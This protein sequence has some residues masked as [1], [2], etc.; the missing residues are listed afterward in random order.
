MDCQK[1]INIF[2]SAIIDL[3]DNSAIAQNTK[4]EMHKNI[5]GNEEN[6]PRLLGVSSTTKNNITKVKKGIFTSCKKNDKCPP[7][8]I[9]AEEVVHD[10]EKKKLTYKNALLKV[11]NLPVFYLPKF[12][13]PDPTVERQS[14]FLQPSINDSDLLGSS[15]N[16]PYFHV[17]SDNKDLTINPVLFDSGDTGKIRMLQG[18]Y[19]Q[20]N[21]NSSFIADFGLTE[22]FKSQS[23]NDDKNLTHFS[24]IMI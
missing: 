23:S 22:N 3:T 6:D 4:I 10:R 20:K 14:G 13:H 2:S 8:S 5:F 17:I 1:V 12:F 21:K 15:I 19:R 11:Y 18:E 7:W 9:S 24:Q 16:V